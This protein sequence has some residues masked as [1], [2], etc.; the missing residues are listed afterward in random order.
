MANWLVPVGIVVVSV[1]A[2]KDDY[3]T[4]DYCWI[5][6]GSPLI[7]AFAVPVLLIACINVVIFIR[8]IYAIFTNTGS[9][10]AW[11]VGDN[12]EKKK[13]KTNTETRT[14]KG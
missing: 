6:A 5:D 14:E 12:E 13:R 4:D 8:V 3:T 7:A 2:A 9:D 1:A 11:K 10:V